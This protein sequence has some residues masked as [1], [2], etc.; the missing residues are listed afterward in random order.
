MP[1]W[2]RCPRHQG[3]LTEAPSW[4]SVPSQKRSRPRT[5][6]PIVG[7]HRES[8]RQLERNQEGKPSLSSGLEC[9][10]LPRCILFHE[11]QTGKAALP[12]RSF[13]TEV[14]APNPS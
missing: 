4:L 14:S 5:F 13:C 2:L 8:D 10:S 12:P 6:Y 7:S 1:L 3:P 11:L 9:L